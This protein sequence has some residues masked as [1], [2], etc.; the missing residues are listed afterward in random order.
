MIVLTDRAIVFLEALDNGPAYRLALRLSATEIRSVDG[1]EESLQS[2][3][4]YARVRRV[5][6]SSEA[7]ALMRLPIEAEKATAGF[8]RQRTQHFMDLAGWLPARGGR[9]LP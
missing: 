1:V 9:K 4:P 6:G 5:D 8:D 2:G 7:L 3:E